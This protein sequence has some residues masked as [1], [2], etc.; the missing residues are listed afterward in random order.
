[1]ADLDLD[2]LEASYTNTSRIAEK[3]VY[4]LIAKAREAEGLRAE[5]DEAVADARQIAQ[6][7]LHAAA[8]IS[9]LTDGSAMLRAEIA[10]LT[11]DLT[12]AR[13]QLATAREALK[14]FAKSKKLFSGS[15]G[16]DD[17]SLPDS[18][19]FEIIMAKTADGRCDFTLGQFRR[20]RTIDARLSEMDCQPVNEGG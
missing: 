13:A 8:H 6:T 15:E 10:T 18:F 11:A 14:P 16:Y 17:P 5:R 3:D 12:T 2:A 20:A 4:A 9:G 1:M 7:N 19:G